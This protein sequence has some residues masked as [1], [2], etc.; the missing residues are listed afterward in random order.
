MHVPIDQFIQCREH[1]YR[2]RGAIHLFVPGGDIDNVEHTWL[3]CLECAR[4]MDRSKAFRAKSRPAFERYQKH[5]RQYLAED[6]RR[7]GDGA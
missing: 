7:G 2:V 4:R 3:V 6:A 5:M 1:G